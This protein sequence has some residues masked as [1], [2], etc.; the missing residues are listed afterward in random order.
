MERGDAGFLELADAARYV[1]G[2]AIARFAVTDDGDIHCVDDLSRFI[3][4]LGKREQSR[5][6]KTEGAVLPAPGD[7]HEG[8]AEPFDQPGLDSI[9]AARSQMTDRFL[10]HGA[11]GFAFLCCVQF[12]FLSFPICDFCSSTL[13]RP[14]GRPDKIQKTSSYARRIPSRA[15]SSRRPTVAVSSSGGI[16]FAPPSTSAKIAICAASSTIRLARAAAAG[17]APKASTP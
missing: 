7:M 12:H 14:C 15:N 9:V 2:V 11:Q 4:H 3:D 16:G 10:Q 8:K 6:G 1:D 5:V 13:G 17:S